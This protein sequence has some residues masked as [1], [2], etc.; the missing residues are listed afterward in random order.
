MKPIEVSKT[1]FAEI[2]NA[3]RSVC[4]DGGIR[5]SHNLRLLYDDFVGEH[6]WGVAMIILQIDESKS[7]ELLKA[8]ILHDVGEAATGDILRTT[9]H[10]LE[11]EFPGTE[12]YLAQQEEKYLRN[13]GLG[14]KLTKKEKQLLAFADVA[15]YVI[16]CFREI[17]SGNRRML[18][19]GLRALRILEKLPMPT[20]QCREFNMVLQSV[21]SVDQDCILSPRQDE[22]DVVEELNF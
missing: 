15:H 21:L 20:R 11:E 14:F 22:E 7:Y 5:R 9:K 13:M 19:Y 1:R 16:V 3:I 8:A 6:S 10:S 12:K 2:R 17:F 4:H 18:D